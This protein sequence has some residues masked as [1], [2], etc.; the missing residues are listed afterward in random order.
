MKTV[1]VIPTLC[2][3]ERI[4]WRVIINEHGDKEEDC[5]HNRMKMPIYSLHLSGCLNYALTKGEQRALAPA[6][7]DMPAGLY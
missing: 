3:L 4:I 7:P 5:I 6:Y 2:L 1:I